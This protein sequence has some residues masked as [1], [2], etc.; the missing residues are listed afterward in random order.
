VADTLLRALTA[1]M[2]EPEV[3]SKLASQSMEATL[4]GPR[5]LRELMEQEITR[6]RAAVA[7]AGL[8]L[9]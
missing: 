6:Y 2:A 3:K 8:R 7:R 4:L 5:P 9:E 1:V